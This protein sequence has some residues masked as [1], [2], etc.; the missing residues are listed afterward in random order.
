[1]RVETVHSKDNIKKVDE[2]LSFCLLFSNTFLTKPSLLQCD[3]PWCV[4]LR[5]P[6]NNHIS[7]PQYILVCSLQYAESNIS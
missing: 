7:P 4:N 1:M 2:L 6:E 3:D 5:L